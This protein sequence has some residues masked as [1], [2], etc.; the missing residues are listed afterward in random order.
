M[1]IRVLY[2]DHCFDG[3]TSAVLT[4]ELLKT[5]YARVS[6]FEYRGLI[7]GPDPFEGG[8]VFDEVVNAV[9][10]FRYHPSQRLTWWF[11]H[12]SSAFAPGGAEL[13][14]HFERD[15]SGRKFFEPETRSCARLIVDVA[16]RHFN[17]DL[18]F[19]R[20]E[21]IEWAHKIDSAD[22]ESPEEAVSLEEP[23]MQILAAIDLSP[24]NIT[25]WLIE[26][27]QEGRSLGEMARMPLIRA[28]AEAARARFSTA[29]KE[30]SARYEMCDNGR[31]FSADLLDTGLYALNKFIPYYL[32]PEA[33]YAIWSFRYPDRIRMTVG[34]NP[35]RRSE[36]AHDIASICERYGGGGHPFVGG[37]SW[38][39]DDIEGARRVQREV[40]DWLAD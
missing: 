27:L 10:D 9:V 23:A 14:D 32:R 3:V 15:E 24:D 38:P 40:I 2:H 22:F 7:H 11:D 12:H 33:L 17:V 16:K 35:W 4:T 34:I 30:T 37:I 5:Q 31:I 20:G 1:K 8:A 13:R 26:K 29:L 28:P 19:N 25:P 18:A 6:G 39:R 21:L 36:R